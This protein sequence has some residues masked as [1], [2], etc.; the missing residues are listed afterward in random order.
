MLKAW[1]LALY[2][3]QGTSLMKSLPQAAHSHGWVMI[4]PLGLYVAHVRVASHG[5]DSGGPL[6]RLFGT[7][8]WRASAAGP[9][10]R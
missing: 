3:A 2:R 10:T 7:T 4:C 5:L 6:S 9:D 1:R 8:A